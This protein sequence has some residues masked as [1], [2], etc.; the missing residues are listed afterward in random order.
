MIGIIGAMHEE[1]E[2]L[3]SLLTEMNVMKIGTFEFFTGKLLGKNV[4]VVEG[5]IGKVNSTICT[6][7]LIERFSIDK[8]IF[9][10]VAGGIVE[11][12]EIGDLVISTDLIEHDFD[13]TA[14]GMEH[15]V[16]P[17][18][19][20]SMF[21]AD[22]KLAKIAEEA[23]LE[24]Y[25]DDKVRRGR[26]VSGD[27]FIA[28]K[29]KLAWLK[30]TFGAS[31]TEMEGASVAHTCHVLGVPF[32]ILRA[33]SDKANSEAQVDFPTFVKESAEKSKQ[34]VEKMLERL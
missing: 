34:V 2:G 1:V 20:T 18:M 24:V 11:D 14:F 9:T 26:I 6:T 12:I 25:E 15:G 33:I 16:I 32:V 3:K 28:S 8:L 13:C 7:L 23:S 10:G 5:G 19:D 30:D 21:T 17:R 31:C 27:Q 29:E 4:V 22:A